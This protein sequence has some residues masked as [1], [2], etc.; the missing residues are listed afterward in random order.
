MKEFFRTLFD[1]RREEMPQVILFFLNYFLLL[2]AQYILKAS[3]RGLFLNKLGI[4]ELPYTYILIAVSAAIVAYCVGFL[5][6]RM[7]ISR[8]IISTQWSL[9][10][11]MV[12]L[13][14]M[15]RYTDWVWPFYVYQV[16]TKISAILTVSQFWTFAN[17]IF[18]ARQAKRLFGPLNLGGVVGAIL[19]GTFTLLFVRALGA[20][21]L[22]LCSAGVMVLASGV[23][24]LA[25]RRAPAAAS[26]IGAGEGEAFRAFDM[27]RMAVKNR[28]LLLISGVIS[29]SVIVGNLVDYQ[30]S[31]IAA[32][33]YPKKEDLVAFLGGFLGIYV[34]AVTL[35]VQFFL[36]GALLR[37]LG[38]G[39]ALR[40]TPGAIMVGSLGVLALPG[41][42]AASALRMADAG[43]RYTVNK[44]G[45][46][47]LYLPIPPEVKNRVKVFVDIVVD[48]VSGGLA[49]LL[50][51]FCTSTL[52]LSIRE[53][54]VVT[55]ILAGAWVALGGIALGAY[56][57]T[58]RKSIE[59]RE[60]NFDS[61]TVNVSDAA[62][63]NVLTQALDS[64]N[65]RQVTYALRL[66]EQVPQVSLA[67]RLPGLLVHPSS[68]VRA[69]TLRLLATRGDRSAIQQAQEL[70]TG[71]DQELRGEAVH[72]VC[73]S[74]PN[75]DDRF[76]QFLNHPDLDVRL[77]ALKTAE[78]Y[79]Y[80]QPLSA[81]SAEWVQGLMA[82]PDAEAEKARA[83][84]ARAL[85]LANP[86]LMPV[87]EHLRRLLDDSNPVI[88][89][90]ALE[91]AGKIRNREDVPL[92]VRCLANR[93]TRAEAQ[94]ALVRYG[95]R[96]VGTLG[97]YLGDPNEGESVRRTLP[98]VLG[99]I[100][101]P[102]A[103]GIL[104][105]NLP[106]SSL[107]MRFQILKALNRIRRDHPEVPIPGEV[108]DRE[109]LQEAKR[110]YAFLSSA[111]ADSAS[112]GPGRT[113]LVRTLEERLDQSLERLFRLLGLRYPPEE[114]YDAYQAVRSSRAQ[115]RAAALEFLD[116]TLEGPLK[117]VLLPIL[118][119]SSWDR[120]Q[121]L[122]K[123]HFGLDALSPE[124]CL[125]ELI[126]SDDRWMKIVALYRAAELQLSSLEA[127]MRSAGTYPDPWVMETAKLA[128]ARINREPF[129]GS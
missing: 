9:V 27:M 20:E 101:T 112:E 15:L 62:T 76:Q 6:A 118:E 22:L 122:A 13:W 90:A 28:H 51:L 119:E 54:S 60:I 16:F 37:R 78:K 49:G 128:L 48:R 33:T 106:H 82:R 58:I 97:D 124:Q 111:Q 75:P 4:R 7:R 70:V 98:R 123:E 86:Q 56:I 66:L 46:E 30:F 99:R 113:L 44:T 36:T 35:T 80:P 77:A 69:A 21:N 67:G 94:A 65:Y 96:I 83:V 47:I 42:W 105:R 10:G 18:D 31:G 108:I 89:N 103:A 126:G 41:I 5:S 95:T 61:I 121:P 19:G 53:I 45:L 43:C 109:I 114:I 52:M 26:Q 110:Y 64:P 63:I 40:F 125:G 74:D 91:A 93:K 17:N 24:W 50:I 23:F 12:L 3:S 68:D 107:E 104:V 72:Y 34:N 88:V 14:W 79:S 25:A 8:L 39:W 120:L 129:Q 85:A 73:R 102:E 71:D 87:A 32:A 117:R 127:V 115:R 59:K 81:I 38:V 100:A 1:V 29:I 57:R 116:N 2:V 55:I 84:A 11:S 92:L